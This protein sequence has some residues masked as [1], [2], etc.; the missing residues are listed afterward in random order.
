MLDELAHR[1]PDGRG[2]FADEGVCLGHLRLAILDLSDA[3]LQP[4]RGPRAPAP[5]QRRD[6]QLPRAARGAAREGPP[7]LDRH[8]Q[9]GDPRRLPRMGRAVRRALQRDVGV[10]HLGRR[11]ADALLLA[12]PI[13]NQAVLLPARRA[14]GSRSRAS[15]GRCARRA[16]RTSAAVRDVPRA[17]LPRPGR[18]DVLRAASSGCRRLTRSSFGPRRAAP[19]GGTGR[20]SRR[21]RR[22]TP[23]PP[24]ARRSSTRFGC[25][26]AAT[27][28]SARACRAASTPRR[29]QSPSRTHGA[30]A[31]EDRHGVLR[32]SRASTSGRTRRPS[33]TRTGA[34]AH[35]VTFDADDLVD[36]LPAIVAGAGRAVRIDLDLRRLVRHARGA[37]RGPDGHAR[38]PGRRR[39]PRRLPRVV[40]LPA[41]RPPPRRAARRGDARAARVRARARPALG[42]GRARD[43]RTSRSALR[44]AAAGGCAARAALVA[45]EL[46]ARRPRRRTANGAV[47]PDRL[48]RQLHLLLTRRGLPEL[49][50]YEDR[51]SMAHSLEARVPLL[52]HRLVRARLLAPR[53]RAHPPRRDEVGAPPRARRSPAAARRRPARQARIRDARGAV[54]PRRARRPRRRRLRVAV[55]PRARLRRRRRRDAAARAA[56]PRRPARR[57]GAVARAQC[58]AVGARASSTHE[59]PRLFIT[60]SYPSDEA[61]ATGVFVLEHA[62]AAARHAEVAVLH[63]DRRH[64]ARGIS[65][66]REPD[67]EFPTWRARIRTGRPALSVAAHVAAGL[68]GYRAVRGAGFD[69]DLVH[70]HF[71][72]AAL[73]ACRSLPRPMVETEHW[74]AFL[75]EDPTTLGAPL[76]LAARVVLRRARTV[77]PVSESLARR[78]CAPP[79]SARR[80]QRRAE[81]R[82]HLALPPRPRRR[83]PPARHRRTAPAPEG[84]RRPAS[85]VRARARA[86]AGRRARHRRRRARARGVRA[87]RSALGLDDGGRVPRASSRSRRSPRCSPSPTCSCSRA[88]STT[89]RACSSRRRRPAFPSSRAASAGSR[90]SSRANG[91]LARA[92]GP[93]ASLADRILEALAGLDRYDRAAIAARADERYG[94]EQVGAH[95]RRRLRRPRSETST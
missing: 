46:R 43:A 69:P 42:R 6:L 60:T 67:A 40:R 21:T 71:F 22:A 91:L 4:M 77:M 12:R 72:L 32:R 38:R 61:P 59:G 10:R 48:R 92:G 36:D 16:A 78:R 25:S 28:R 14:T 83:R 53:R 90:R 23:S 80:F 57:H 31:P 86:A 50:R 47:F 88:A 41:V 7:V 64:D 74:T 34:E 58:R 15:R 1:G 94:V 68:A 54:P 2:V 84:D 95:A 81:R 37:P 93:S 62:R 11:A 89:I 73:P 27:S 70:A 9:R 39:D 66:H 79:A 87:P 18:G 35:W 51:N 24:C 26:C 56:P 65:V 30:R 82:R 33:S 29:S 17:G 52:D 13:R 75:P 5:A 63:L 85:R 76:T 55:V 20:S 45:P 3:G 44:L 49:L 8:G 19:R